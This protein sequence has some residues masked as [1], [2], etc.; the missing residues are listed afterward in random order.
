MNIMQTNCIGCLRVKPINQAL[1]R[2]L[3]PKA[4]PI[5]QN[6]LESVYQAV[7][8]SANAIVIRNSRLRVSTVSESA[9]MTTLDSRGANLVRNSPR[10]SSV[11]TAIYL[12]DF[13]VVTCLGGICVRLSRF[14][15][16]LKD[17]LA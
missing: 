10:A 17:P 7:E 5:S 15:R 11:R 13:Q 12:H 1:R 8:M 6:A 16:A 3:R 2:H 9:A 14:Q 4:M